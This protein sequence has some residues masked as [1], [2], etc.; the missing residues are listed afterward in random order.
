MALQTANPGREA[1]ISITT[2]KQVNVIGNDHVTSER[3][4]KRGDPATSISL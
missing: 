2:N 1:E 4:I 3:N